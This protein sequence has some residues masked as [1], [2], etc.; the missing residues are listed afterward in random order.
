MYAIPLTYVGL[1]KTETTTDLDRFVRWEYKPADRTQV[2]LT[3]RGGFVL[4]PPRPR[5]E[6]GRPLRARIRAALAA[7]RRRPITDSVDG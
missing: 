7:F 6:T 1:A 5:K 4:F 2:I 3:A